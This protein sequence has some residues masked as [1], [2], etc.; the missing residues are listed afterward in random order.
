[1]FNKHDYNKQKY[2]K[3]ILVNFPDFFK[4]SQ[5]KSNLYMKG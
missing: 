4:H 1:M 2:N 5:P 3:H